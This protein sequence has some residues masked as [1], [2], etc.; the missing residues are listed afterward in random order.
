MNVEVTAGIVLSL[1]T[2][3]VAIFVSNFFERYEKKIAKIKTAILGLLGKAIDDLVR[4]ELSKRGVTQLVK[5]EQEKKH[6]KKEQEKNYED[7]ITF[8]RKSSFLKYANEHE[9][10]LNFEDCG[11]QKVRRLALSIGGFVVPVILLQ[12]EG[13][14]FAFGLLWLSADFAFFS[15]IFIDINNMIKRIDALYKEYIIGQQS[16]G[17]Y[18]L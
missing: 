17:G 8:M 6:V 1:I 16:F 4:I 11:D 15:T 12:M 2:L 13:N 10:M 7:F 14:L 5:K 3:S 9:E 18:D